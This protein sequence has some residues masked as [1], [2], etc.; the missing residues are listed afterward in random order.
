MKL[1]TPT[2][3]HTISTL[4][5]SQNWCFVYI[6]IRQLRSALLGRPCCGCRCL[7][8]SI[9]FSEFMLI[10]FSFFF[11]FH[12]KTDKTR[13]YSKSVIFVWYENSRWRL[14]GAQS[15]NTERASLNS[16]A[17]HCQQQNSCLW[18]AT[19]QWSQP[20]QTQEGGAAGAL[21]VRPH[22]YHWRT[23]W[24]DHFPWGALSGWLA[25]ARCGRCSGSFG[26]YLEA[27]RSTLQLRRRF[28]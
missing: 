14:L 20:P 1:P 10:S 9:H 18:L 19:S 12:K 4:K 2:F 13:K 6:Y 15:I 22:P 17:Y 16:I 26:S 7:P 8:Y 21:G 27:G 23:Q 11:F 24:P 3:L 28:F 5:L 25:L